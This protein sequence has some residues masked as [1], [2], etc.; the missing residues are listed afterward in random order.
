ML[1]RGFLAV[2]DS[3]GQKPAVLLLDAQPPGAD[4]ERLAKAGRI[5][6]LL[7]PR[8]TPPGTESVKSPYL[9]NFNL[10]AL[11]AFLVGKTLVGLRMDDAIRAV[12]WL[13]AR[14]DVARAAIT[15]YGNGALG[16]VA[17]H[18]A[19]LDGRIGRVVIENS[20][21]TYRRIVDQ[22]V[23]RNVSEV[24]IPGVLRKYDTG[25]LLQALY[26]R[27]VTIVNPRDALG[28]AV[29]EP[30][31][32]RTLARIGLV[33]AFLSDRRLGLPGRIRLLFGNAREHLFD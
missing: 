4:F 11:R 21:I 25:E 3:A 8:P 28:D 9:G 31:F 10:L 5:V 18:A 12:D 19:A 17:L 2:P 6:L 33:Y 23:H 26:P 7:E 14:Q 29:S 16:M 20:L 30:E 27:P 13:Y 32:H 1:V 15:L 24:V 22:V